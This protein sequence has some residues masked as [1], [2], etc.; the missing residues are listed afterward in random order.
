MQILDKGKVWLKRSVSKDHSDLRVWGI[1]EQAVAEKSKGDSL[2]LPSLTPSLSSFLPSL[3]R[4][5]FLP[6][7][8]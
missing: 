1:L 4:D 3:L 2:L 7:H 6:M 8:N 5:L